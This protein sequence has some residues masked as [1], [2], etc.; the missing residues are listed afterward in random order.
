MFFASFRFWFWFL[1]GRGSGGD[2]DIPVGILGD[3]DGKSSSFPTS[4][5]GL[6]W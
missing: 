5:T 3:S 1:S 6:W 4:V 2:S